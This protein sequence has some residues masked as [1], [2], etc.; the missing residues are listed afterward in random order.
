[1][2][3]DEPSFRRRRTEWICGFDLFAE[4]TAGGWREETE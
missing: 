4:K 3:V 2:M 1:M